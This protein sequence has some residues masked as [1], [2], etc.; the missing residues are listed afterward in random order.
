MFGNVDD[1]FKIQLASPEDMK[2]IKAEETRKELIL[3]RAINEIF[4]F[5]VSV[6]E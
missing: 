5:S 2:A 4:S 3:K 6:G 1:W